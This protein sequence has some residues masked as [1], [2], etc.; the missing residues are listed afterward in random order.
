[1]PNIIE[2]HKDDFFVDHEIIVSI[3]NRCKSGCSLKTAIQ[4][5]CG[6]HIFSDYE[7]L[8]ILLVNLL[9]EVTDKKVICEIVTLMDITVVDYFVDSIVNSTE[10]VD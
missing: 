1:M 5:T 8:I 10:S 4:A 2:R 7:S 9:A 6:D 3:Y